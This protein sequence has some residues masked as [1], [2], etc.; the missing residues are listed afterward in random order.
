[1]SRWKALAAVHDV[2][3]AELRDRL[4]DATET[5]YEF[6]RVLEVSPSPD[7]LTESL[8]EL[9]GRVRDELDAE[10][11]EI[12]QLQSELHEAED[13]LR[14]VDALE[15]E[16]DALRVERDDLRG[17]LDAAQPLIDAY[18]DAVTFARR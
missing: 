3:D 13:R 15:A 17:R 5:L 8:E 16:R 10:A 6:A 9:A 18:S 11:D 1:M 4:V 2:P 12:V 7:R 14:A